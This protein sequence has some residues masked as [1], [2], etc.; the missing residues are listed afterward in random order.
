MF[1]SLFPYGSEKP[2]VV[3]GLTDTMK[4]LN[5]LPTTIHDPYT[6]VCDVTA[7]NVSIILLFHKIF[8]FY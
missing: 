1:S 2:F 4:L 6:F 5:E 3:I 7:C 8:F